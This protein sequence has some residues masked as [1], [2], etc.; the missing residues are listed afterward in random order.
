MPGSRY[1]TSDV[2][3]NLAGMFASI[4]RKKWY[5]LLLTLLAGALF[6]AVFSSI[7]SRYKSESQILIEKRESVFTRVGN[8]NLSGAPSFDAE[9]VGSQVQI[10]NSQDLALA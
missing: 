7:S 10:L 8:E 5:L 3:I 4:W 9:T 1:L 6:F 2:D